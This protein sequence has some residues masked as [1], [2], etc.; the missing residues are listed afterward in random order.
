MF[1]L[2]VR[3]TFSSFFPLAVMYMLHRV[4]SRRMAS[5]LLSRTLQPHL[6]MYFR[7]AT[8]HQKR[9]FVTREIHVWMLQRCTSRVA[10]RVIYFYD[11]RVTSIFIAVRILPTMSAISLYRITSVLNVSYFI[12][13]LLFIFIFLFL[14][15][16]KPRNGKIFMKTLSVHSENLVLSRSMPA[17]VFP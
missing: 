11:S 14:Q 12:I 4:I 3:I 10:S 9:L 8:L 2:L 13:F 1:S 5:D 6:I 16:D 7:A 15:A 17:R